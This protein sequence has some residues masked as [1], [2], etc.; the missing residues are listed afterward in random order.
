MALKKPTKNTR[1]A[2]KKKP[3]ATKPRKSSVKK[4]K[5]AGFAWKGLLFKLVLICMLLGAGLVVYLDAWVTDKFEGKRWSLPAQ[6]Y[7]R[8]LELYVGQPLNLR[9]VQAELNMLGYHKRFQLS[10]PGQYVISGGRMEIYTRS[11]RFWNETAPAQRVSLSVQGGVVTLLRA[12]D[13]D[14]SLLSLEPL[15][16][17]GI[18][19]AH[20]EDRLLIQLEN[21]PQFLVDALITV[22]DKKFLQ[23]SRCFTQIHCSCPVGKCQGWSCGTG[24]Q[25]V[26]SAAGEELL[27]DQ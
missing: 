13:T 6:V 9:D 20:N 8:P 11:F 21:V 2:A 16:V 12:D 26:D 1:S 17:G 23:S 15:L 27:F 5:K 10:K 19:P 18:Y 3:A 7:A 4:G 14:I 25:Y 22:E 24:W